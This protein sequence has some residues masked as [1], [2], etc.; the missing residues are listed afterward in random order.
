MRGER[1]LSARLQPDRVGRPQGDSQGAGGPREDAEVVHLHSSPLPT[2]W[3]TGA[4]PFNIQ[5]LPLV[6][7]D[8]HDLCLTGV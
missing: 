5:E 6:I 7:R 3:V 1:G 4:K 2:C 8:A